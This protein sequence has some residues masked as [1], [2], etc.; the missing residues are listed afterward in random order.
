M[1]APRTVTLVLNDVEVVHLLYR[2]EGVG[3]R[4]AKKPSIPTIVKARDVND[5]ILGKLDAAMKADR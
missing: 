1:T 3:V 4:L 5:A 2:L